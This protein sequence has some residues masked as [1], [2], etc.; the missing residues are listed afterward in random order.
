MVHYISKYSFVKDLPRGPKMKINQHFTFLSILISKNQ[1]VLICEEFKGKCLKN[2]VALPKYPT[3]YKNGLKKNQNKN[4]NNILKTI[5]RT[6]RWRKIPYCNAPTVD[7]DMFHDFGILFHNFSGDV[8]KAWCVTLN[9]R[10]DL[11]RDLEKFQIR[12]PL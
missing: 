11:E 3:D 4:E 9:L 2:S 5:S 6:T 8:R 12:D 10:F 1:P 7:I